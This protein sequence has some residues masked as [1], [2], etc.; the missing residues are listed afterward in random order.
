MIILHASASEGR[1]VFWGE[2]SL[3]PPA[4]PA[5]KTVRRNGEFRD[6]PSRFG[7]AGDQLAEVLSGLAGGFKLL[8]DQSQ[9]WTAWLPSSEHGPLPSSPLLIDLPDEPGEITLRAW[10]TPALVLTTE[11]AVAVLLATMDRTTAAPGVV[12]GKALAYW[13]NVLRFAGALVARQQYL[14]GLDVQ[15]DGE[16]ALARWE[17]VL[18]GQD[19]VEGE[20]LA[21]LMPHACRA[22]CHH[23]ADPPQTAASGVLFQVVTTFVDHLVRAQAPRGHRRPAVRESA[24]SVGARPPLR[25]WRH[26]GRRG[27]ARSTCGD[28]AAVAAPGRACR[29]G[30][31][32]ALLAARRAENR[33]SAPGRSLASRLSAA[34]DGRPEPARTRQGRV[35]PARS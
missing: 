19:R 28:S 24:R 32:P 5:K 2:T 27:R 8:K 20:R 15:A 9:Q 18:V 1:L 10:K 22:L 16:S 17:P 4:K 3:E 25:E 30:T 12:V 35:E 34:S 21:R 14:P 23:E 13:S 31:V 11:Q 7:L 33:R 29:V 6:R 26:D